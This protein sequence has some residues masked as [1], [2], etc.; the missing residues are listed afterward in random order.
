MWR[1]FLI[2]HFFAQLVVCSQ[3]VLKEHFWSL[4]QLMN[5][6]FESNFI[7]LRDLS[8]RHWLKWSGLLFCTL[9]NSFS[10]FYNFFFQSALFCS[11]LVKTNYSF[12]LIMLSN[13][14]IT[15]KVQKFDEYG[16]TQTLLYSSI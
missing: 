5:D 1:F 4:V 9:L 11:V 14:F 8:S 2:F 10:I 6:Y 7:I 15:T 3:L 16:G 12:K 13:D